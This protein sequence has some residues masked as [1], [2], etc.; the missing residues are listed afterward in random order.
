MPYYRNNK[1]TARFLLPDINQSGM[2][3]NQD[4]YHRGF[5]PSQTVS[6]QVTRTEM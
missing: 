1:Q 4:A 2:G 3:I 5:K 6:Y